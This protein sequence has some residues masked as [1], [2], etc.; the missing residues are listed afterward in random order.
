M[1]KVAIIMAATSELPVVRKATDV[2][3]GSTSLRAACLLRPPDAGTGA[4]FRRARAGAR[5]RRHSSLPAGMAASPR[6]GDGRRHDAAGHRHPHQKLAGRTDALLAT[7]QMPSASRWRRSP[8]TGRK[9]AAFLAAQILALS[10]ETL[11]EKL[12]ARRAADR[13]GDPRKGPPAQ[14][15]GSQSLIQKTE[16]VTMKLIYPERPKTICPGQRPLPAEVQ[17]DCTGKDGVFDP[18]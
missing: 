6:R 13:G 17:D 14:R 10:D 5:L 1:K 16:R 3:R 7:V 15:R 11:T 4:V 12:E 9:T 8:S 2:L 18:A